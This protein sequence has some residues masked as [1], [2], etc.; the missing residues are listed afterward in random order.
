MEPVTVRVFATDF[1]PPDLEIQFV[2]GY[3]KEPAHGSR[4]AVEGTHPMPRMS[5]ALEKQAVIAARLGGGH[6]LKLIKAGSRV[7]AKP[8]PAVENERFVMTTHPEYFAQCARVFFDVTITNKTFF[9]D[10]YLI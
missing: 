8:L 9:D 7:G 10:L 5:G 4:G 6:H 1:A 3:F 2:D